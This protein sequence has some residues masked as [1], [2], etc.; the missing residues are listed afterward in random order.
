MARG[1]EP[2]GSD[3]VSLQSRA[4]RAEPWHRGRFRAG[5]G[6]HTQ[7]LSGFSFGAVF[8]LGWVGWHTHPTPLGAGSGT[9]GCAQRCVGCAG[10][11]LCA[12]KAGDAH[13]STPRLNEQTGALLRG[14]KNHSL[15]L[16]LGTPA[17]VVTDHGKQI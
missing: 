16:P 17:A 11:Q 13:T 3:P 6:S 7:S 14:S 9:L 2:C 4:G 10:D 15:L 12:G 8:G 1:E 5:Q